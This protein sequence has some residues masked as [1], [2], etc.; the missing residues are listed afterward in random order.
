MRYLV[1]FNKLK[2]S[3]RV[4]ASNGRLKVDLNYDEMVTVIKMLLSGIDVDEEF[5]RRTYPD[6]AEAIA[7]GTYRNAK[8]HFVENGYFE[9]RR[10]FE[11][12]VDEKWYIANNPDVELGLQDGTIASVAE[13]FREHGYTEGRPPM[14]V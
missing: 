3:I 6:V 4:V 8:Q 1:P 2:D 5:Y 12:A 9:G 11:M 7:A 14:A 10:P 13:H